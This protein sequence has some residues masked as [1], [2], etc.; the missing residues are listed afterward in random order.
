MTLLL[1]HH[2]MAEV[3]DNCLMDA[4]ADQVDM[5]NNGLLSECFQYR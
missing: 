2:L 1:Y 4:N 3:S 5:D